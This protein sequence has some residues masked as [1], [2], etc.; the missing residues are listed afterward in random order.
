MLILQKKGGKLK[1]KQARSLWSLNLGSFISVGIKSGSGFDQQISSLPTLKIS[2]SLDFLIIDINMS[3]L[4]GD[5]FTASELIFRII[6][7]NNFPS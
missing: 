5:P 2:L 6:L 3:D 7:N 4:V 1:K